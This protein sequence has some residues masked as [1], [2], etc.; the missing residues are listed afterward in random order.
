[1]HIPIFFLPE[2][3]VL[4]PTVKRQSGLLFVKGGGGKFGAYIGFPY[5]ISLGDT[6]NLTLTPYIGT[7]SSM[8]GVEAETIFKSGRAQI[9]ALYKPQTNDKS[10]LISSN[11]ISRFGVKGKHFYNIDEQVRWKNEWD[12]V[13]DP[14]FTKDYESLYKRDVSGQSPSK[15]RSEINYFSSHYNYGLIGGGV[16]SNLYGSVP[17]TSSYL[18]SRVRYRTEALGG[19]GYSCRFLHTGRNIQ[20]GASRS[21]THR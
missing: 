6:T 2:I 5:F 9:E 7:E 16:A 12:F 4:G 17:I 3:R 13:S 20:L 10:D 14:K 8:L 15:I 18:E 19:A 21:R 11:Q 1:M